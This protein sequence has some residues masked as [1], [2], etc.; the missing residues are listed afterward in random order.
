MLLE[1]KF[2]FN[3]LRATDVVTMLSKAVL[4]TNLMTEAGHSKLWAGQIIPN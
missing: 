4:V 1:I 2:F 3:V